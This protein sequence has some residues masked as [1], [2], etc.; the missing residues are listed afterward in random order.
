MVYRC[1]STEVEESRKE[2]DD[3][4]SDLCLSPTLVPN[5]RFA[6]MF[7]GISSA[8]QAEFNAIINGYDKLKEERPQ[9]Y[10]Q[11]ITNKNGIPEIL[12]EFRPAKC[13]GDGLSLYHSV[14]RGF[15]SK[16]IINVE[17]LRRNVTRCIL[18]SK[19]VNFDYYFTEENYKNFIELCNKMKNDSMFS[20]HMVF[21]GLTVMYP[22]YLFFVIVKSKCENGNVSIDVLNYTKNIASY[23]KCIYILYD[24]IIGHYSHLNLYNKTRREEEEKHHFK[25]DNEM[26]QGLLVEF[27]RRELKYEGRVD[28]KNA[29]LIDQPDIRSNVQDDFDA[30]NV[31]MEEEN[32][33]DDAQPLPRNNRAKVSSSS[34][35]IINR[36][37]PIP[38]DS[39]KTKQK[40]V[41]IPVP[42]DG[43]CLFSSLCTVLS[44][45]GKVTVED[46]RRQ[47]ADSHRKSKTINRIGLFYESNKNF[48]EYCCDIENTDTWGGELEI[49][50]IAELYGIL[51]CVVDVNSEKSC[52]N[53]TKF[54]SNGASFEK[55]CYII[56]NRCHYQPLCL[57]VGDNSNYEAA[58]FSSNDRKVEELLYEFISETFPNYKFGSCNNKTDA[59]VLVQQ[60]GERSCDELIDPG[61]SIVMNASTKP[62]RKR[63]LSEIETKLLPASTL[64]SS[65]LVNKR[66]SQYYRPLP[67]SDN[68]PTCDSNSDIPNSIRQ[69]YEIN[70]YSTIDPKLNKKMETLKIQDCLGTGVS[71]PVTLDFYNKHNEQQI[72]F[73]TEPTRAFRARY[74][75]DYVPKN[76]RKLDGITKSKLRCPTYFADR[77]KN[78]FLDLLIPKMILFDQTP[79]DPRSIKVEICI[80]T[81]PI[82]GCIYIH[83]YF[84]FYK[85]E[86]N[87]KY[88]VDNPIFIQDDFIEGCENL[89]DTN[90][91]LKMRL[92]LT[93][94][95]LLESQLLEN[96]IKPF[97]SLY[98]NG[99]ADKTQFTKCDA[100]KQK[101]HL[102]DL[103]FAVTLWFRDLNTNDYKRYIDRQYISDISSKMKKY[104][105]RSKNTG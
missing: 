71:P 8:D 98:S 29:K 96:Q 74:L 6:S 81:R 2:Y 86:K 94:I 5:I 58:I 54:P 48:E 43:H 17:D 18:V 23:K 66:S 92:Y 33:S 101:F 60:P 41:Q 51:I 84:Q 50:A 104:K 31:I 9:E 14:L 62:S 89:I 47:A 63:K 85:P 19:L 102:D 3:D 56:L 70:S 53:V 91:I 49:N 83:P 72:K 88:S 105:Y 45:M 90:G 25:H 68:M 27:I 64:G 11:L 22:N 36:D 87:G 12:Y 38:F 37:E 16:D 52:I 39:I 46:L 32:I 79:L 97:E 100:F 57:C 42:T 30:T 44:S 55:C 77:N 1:T 75:R 99:Q 13:D 34:M 21:M 4:I 28:L 26:M 61:N 35:P 59:D 10:E 93:V 15:D 95:N 20:G 82:N 80:V 7:Q 78:H 40:I 24:G 69:H 65:N 103:C 73:Q 76:E 67:P